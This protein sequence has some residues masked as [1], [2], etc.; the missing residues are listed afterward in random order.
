[1]E[2]EERV[3]LCTTT[4]YHQ[5]WLERVYRKFTLMCKVWLY[6]RPPNFKIYFV[7]NCGF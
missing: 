3:F 4:W 7:Q 5:E 6:R 1:M 2:I